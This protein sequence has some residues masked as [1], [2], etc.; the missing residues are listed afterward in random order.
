MKGSTQMKNQTITTT[1]ITTHLL[2]TSLLL[3]LLFVFQ[4]TP[5]AQGQS[6]DAATQAEF[7]E[8]C[9][10]AWGAGPDLPSAGVRL[11]GVY[12]PS[13][14][15]FYAMGG[16]ASDA[17][18]SDFTHPFEYDPPTNTC[19]TKAATYP[20]NQ[21]N[22]MAC[23][24]LTV[25]G[26]PM[27]CCVGGSAATQTTATARVFF[28]NPLTDVLTTL[29]AADNWPGD[30]GGTILPGGFA[31]TGNKLYI[32]GG[33]NINVGSTSEIWQFD[34]TAAVGLKWTQEV[35]TPV[36]IMYAPTAAIGGIIY[37]GGASDFSGG[38]V[39]DTTNSFSFN[40]GTNSTGMIAAIP[41]A[42]GETRALNYGGKV[43]VMG[44]GRV[45]PN[46]SNEVDVYD[47]STN[48]WTTGAP[49]TT[50]RRNF[51]TD[52]DGARIWLA[53]G[54]AP[55][56]PV[57]TMEI[58]QCN[59]P[60][61]SGAVSR[62]THGGAGT[63]DVSLPL[64]GVTGV[65]CRT[66]GA[67][68]DFTMVVT[69]GGSVSV[70]GSPQAQ[71]IS[72]T[73]TVG[74]GGVSNG[75]MVT[76]SGSAVTVPLT[77][78]ADQQTIMVRLNGVTV[79]TANGDVTIPMSRLLGDSNGNRAV[80]AGDIAQVKARSGQAVTG[81]NFRSDLNANGSINAGDIGI[82]KANSGHGVP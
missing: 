63:F 36:G 55:T 12:F 65:E 50:A 56:A 71:V 54:Y 16:R 64:S 19:A 32:L 21:V 60:I 17:V 51:P 13:T 20:D 33:F 76:V 47:P 42:T 44:G 25:S 77:S 10:P 6:L 68:N 58:Y 18:G 73:G 53:G 66:G 67:T 57:A 72:G 59:A 39:I 69:F 49:F 61:P 43:Y 8:V 52:T 26:A 1:V 41:R 24:V 48:T 5:L 45:A 75:G 3:V 28:Y 23:G 2:R 4:L 62:K 38:L 7:P 70:S 40:P 46:P 82:A 27:I 11:V 80:N 34:P 37:V 15:R 29:T 14:N 22:N 9:T 31:V 74:S 35:N 81:A 79:G 78:V 30:S